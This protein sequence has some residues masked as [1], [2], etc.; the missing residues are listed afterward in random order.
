MLDCCLQR[1]ITNPYL[2]R[3][4]KFDLRVYVLAT[5]LEPLKVYIYEEG[6]V[7]FAV[8][9]FSLD[10]STISD[11]RIHV[12]NF[13]VNKKSEKFLYNICPTEPE[14]HKWT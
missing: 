12:T 11:T 1:Y 7:R 14:G 10:P 13:D 5:S 4:C 3:R 8:N 2:I 6:L 9:E